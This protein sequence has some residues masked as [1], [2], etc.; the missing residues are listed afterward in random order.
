MK[1][2]KRFNELNI[3]G[4]YLDKTNIP[5]SD[6]YSTSGIKKTTSDLLSKKGKIFK[7]E[8]T[9]TS[10]PILNFKVQTKSGNKT[11]HRIIFPTNFLDQDTD[12]TTMYNL[13]DDSDVVKIPMKELLEDKFIVTE[14][15]FNRIHFTTFEDTNLPASDGVPRDLRGIGLGY[16]IYDN[17]IKHLGF[18]SSNNNHTSNESMS[19][20]NKIATDPDFLCIL[21]KEDKNRGEI[22]AIHKG[23]AETEK[24]AFEFIENLSPNTKE[25]L[26][27]DE[28]MKLP[29]VV[30]IKTKFD[31]LERDPDGFV[32]TIKNGKTFVHYRPFRIGEE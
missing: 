13:L 7:D 11:S 9:T 10:E 30:E 21:L 18:A 14:G 16:L 6:T 25:I 32:K 2:L 17:F 23:F 1:H 26:I 3:T 29:K 28:L 12:T 27:D 8:P 15:K 31:S 5:K 20:W 24:M 19:L 22:M 4:T